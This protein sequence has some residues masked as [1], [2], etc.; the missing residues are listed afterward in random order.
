MLHN[1]N[2][3]E[4]K[5][6]ELLRALLNSG[7]NLRR[8]LSMRTDQAG[9]ECTRAAALSGIVHL[10]CVN[11]GLFQVLEFLWGDDF[12]DVWGS[13]HLE[14]VVHALF[15]RGHFAQIPCV[16]RGMAAKNIFAAGNEE[17]RNMYVQHTLLSMKDQP[18]A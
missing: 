3:S 10:I 4:E 5:K 14:M 15:A 12:I 7:F 13:Q 6:I 17:Y 9:E 11:D 18:E 8:C 1:D 16:L 2:V